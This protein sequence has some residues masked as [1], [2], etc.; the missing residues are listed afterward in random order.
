MPEPFDQG[1]VIGRMR[2]VESV[3]RGYHCICTRCKRDRVVAGRSLRIK[4]DV[5]Y[6]RCFPPKK[7]PKPVVVYSARGYALLEEAA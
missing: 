3:T 7:S 4:H 5:D 1:A 2:V 6:V